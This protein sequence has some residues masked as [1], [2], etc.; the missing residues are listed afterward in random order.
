[1]TSME[2]FSYLDCKHPTYPI[3]LCA[4]FPELL[5]NDPIVKCKALLEKQQ[6][7]TEIRNA[8]F[9]EYSEKWLVSH[10]NTTTLQ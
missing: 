1:M 3:T 2:V 10:K 9:L 4:N 7:T 8:G 6:K 5:G